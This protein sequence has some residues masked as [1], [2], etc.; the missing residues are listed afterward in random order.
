MT[1]RSKASAYGGVGWSPREE[2]LRDEIGTV[3][4]QCGVES[5]WAP[6]KSVMLHCPGQEMEDITEP[7]RVQMLEVPDYNLVCEQ[8]DALADAYRDGGVSVFYVEPPE[9]PPPNL[10]F[11]ADLLFMTPEG[12]ILSRPASTVR[13]GEE[14]FVARRLAELGIPILLSVRGTGVFEG[15]DAAW[16]DPETVLIGV[17]LRTNREGA[18]QVSSLLHE[19]DIE[20]I[21]VDLP[22]GA[23]HLMGNLRFPGRD[24][25]VCRSG[26]TPYSAMNAL[27]ERGYSLVFAPDEEEVAK[28]MAMNFVTIGPGRILMVAG[29]PTSQSFYEDVGIKCSTVEIHE[30]TKA[31]GGIGCLTAILEREKRD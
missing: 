31:A 10:M 17:G 13:A 8:H 27:R 9:T 26:R 16:I 25:A 30:L 29:N 2:S 21:H 4:G 19:M 24:L 28:G 14:R 3:W 1:E 6:L 23:M 20:A 11:M 12:A 15:A 18:S 5:E 22:H 7:D